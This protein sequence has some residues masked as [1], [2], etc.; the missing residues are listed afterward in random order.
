[1]KQSDLSALKV[2]FGSQVK[3]NVPLAGYTSARVGGPADVLLTVRSAGE[4]SKVARLIWAVECKFQLIGGG[5]NVLIS[6]KGIRGLT[7]LN[8]ARHV[9]FELNADSPCVYVES[10]AGLNAIRRRFQPE[11]VRELVVV[12]LILCILLLFGT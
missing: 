12:V 8:R 6:D 9:K 1:M 4:L 3:E 5:S 7:V 10:G 11:Q 2:A